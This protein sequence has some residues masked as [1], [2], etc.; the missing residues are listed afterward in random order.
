MDL[1]YSRYSSPLEFMRLYIE[2]GR[3]GE[4]VEEIFGMEQKRRQE[5]AEDEEEQKLW[6]MY[7]HSM[8][9]KSYADWKKE[10]LSNNKSIQKPT[11]TMNDEQVEDTKRQARSI[12]QRSS[13]T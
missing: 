13:P 10:V 11:L 7:L 9:G 2:Q 6:E 3:F 1:L 12:L 8:S 4:F 5:K